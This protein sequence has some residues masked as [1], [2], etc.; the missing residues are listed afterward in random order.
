MKKYFERDDIEKA[1]FVSASACP[2]NSTDYAIGWNAAIDA[3]LENAPS[4]WAKD[5]SVCKPVKLL[6]QSDSKTLNGVYYLDETRNLVFTH[7][8]TLEFLKAS[9]YS[10]V[11]EEEQLW[12]GGSEG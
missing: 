9:G 12:N 5:L 1:K 8:I 7:A 2:E 3:I 6:R 10:V 4:F 11:I